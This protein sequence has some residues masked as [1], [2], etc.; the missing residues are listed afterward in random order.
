MRRLEKNGFVEAVAAERDSRGK[1]LY[2]ATAAG[3]LRL[4]GLMDNCDGLTN[5]SADLFRITL[6]C[7]GHVDEAFRRRVVNDYR[8]HLLKVRLHSELMAERILGENGPPPEERR[9]ALLALEH[10]RM[11]AQS[12][13][14]WT[15]SFLSERG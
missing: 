14:D 4:I 13:L 1:R 2:R 6:G 8:G 9:F 10:Q 12:E 7:F 5:R 15:E 3:R 11:V